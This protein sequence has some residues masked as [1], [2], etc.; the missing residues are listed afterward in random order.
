MRDHLRK[1]WRDR[2]R[3]AAEPLE[4]GGRD[5]AD[6]AT[7]DMGRDLAFAELAAE[8]N[9]LAE[10]EAAIQRLHRGVYGYCEATGEP[11]PPER[12]RALPWGRYTV[13]AEAA[14]EKSKR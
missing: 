7:G 6:L 5:Q 11:I 1:R 12:L 14:R 9:S 8:E 2:S 4:K 3:V 10:V 13:E